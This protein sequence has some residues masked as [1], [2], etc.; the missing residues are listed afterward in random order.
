MDRRF[1]V[2]SKFGARDLASYN[3]RSEDKMPYIVFVVDELAIDGHVTDRS[4]RTHR[5]PVA[6]GPRGRHPPGRHAASVGR[7]ADRPHQGQHSG[8]HV[9]FAVASA[10]DSRTI[11][12]SDGSRKLLGRGDM[13]YQSSD[14]ASPKRIQG[15]FITD[16][17]V[18]RVVEFLTSKYGP[19]DYEPAVTEKSYGGTAFSRRHA[20]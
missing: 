9:A 3:Q 20:D 15:A 18:R 1:D 4:R 10:T 13:L 8:A 14:M 6:D 2:L 5:S 11:F 17:E 16:D 7:R 12:G 19:P